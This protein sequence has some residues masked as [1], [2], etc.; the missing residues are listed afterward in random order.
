M[1]QMIRKVPFIKSNNTIKQALVL[2]NQNRYKCLLVINNQKNIEG[3]LTDGD[4]RRAFIK[5]KKINTRVKDVCNRKFNFFYE[6]EI[7]L[8]KIK[9]I[10][11][12]KNLNIDLI[13]IINKKKKLIRVYSQNDFKKFLNKKK[14]LNID[15]KAFIMAGGLGKRMLPVSTVLPKPLMPVGNKTV[16]ELIMDK[17][18][19]EGIHKFFLSVNYKKDLIKAYFKEISLRYNIK[20]IE[21]KTPLGTAGSLFFL[22]KDKSKNFLVMNCDNLISINILNFFYFHKSNNYDM[23]IVTSQ[24][25]L[26]I[27]YGV[28]R[29][30]DNKFFERIE[31]KP[32]YEFLINT[33]VYLISKKVISTIKPNKKLDMNTLINKIKA[34]KFKIGIYPIN[35]QSWIDVG[36]WDKYNKFVSKIKNNF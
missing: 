3:T 17:L 4:I 13:P 6:N 24:K 35:E 32:R 5:N 9:K 21:E 31:E 27:P 18:K 23:T 30:N 15:L 36:Q 33:G 11:F 34:K 29:I 14:N 12:Q 20:F 1:E 25:N 19:S 2:L 26:K 28:C 8:K 10:L 22:K 16:L 7:N